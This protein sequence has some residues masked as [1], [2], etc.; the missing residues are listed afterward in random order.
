TKTRQVVPLTQ[1]SLSV[2][3]R[4]DERVR[5]LD[6]RIASDSGQR[7]NPIEDASLYVFEKTKYL[8]LRTIDDLATLV[9]QF[10][11]TSQ[12]LSRCMVPTTPVTAGQSLSYVLDIAAA[13]QGES[14]LRSYFQSL[15]RTS[16]A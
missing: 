12:K 4:T 16:T 1:H 15:K 11:D 6:E 10:E 3:M 13:E 7:F 5:W 8:Q 14:E 9:R 2:Y